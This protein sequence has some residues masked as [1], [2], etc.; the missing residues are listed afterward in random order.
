M[1]RSAPPTPFRTWIHCDLRE[2]GGLASEYQFEVLV[3][4]APLT[5]VPRTLDWF[6][7]RGVRQI[8]ALGTTS[9]FSKQD[10]RSEAERKLAAAYA[11]AERRTRERCRELDIRFLLIRP[12][13]IYDGYRDAN[14]RLIRGV[15]NRFGL[16][17]VVRGRCGLRQPLHANDLARLIGAGIGAA[18][19]PAYLALNLGGGE[20]LAYDELVGRVFEAMGKEPRMI[21]C[22]AVILRSAVRVL[23]LL[24]QFR[25]LDPALVD[26]M[27][28]DLVFDDGQAREIFSFSP[29]SFRI[30]EP[31]ESSCEGTCSAP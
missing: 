30:E 7:A 22:P 15:V 31:I 1:G 2:I 26:R 23:R 5:L 25:K 20:V 16:F 13:M 27:T 14:V 8:I 21:R 28:Q 18:G 29:G 4:L 3:Q 24:P 6:A 10:S 17:P 19:L 12:T 11:D 9:R